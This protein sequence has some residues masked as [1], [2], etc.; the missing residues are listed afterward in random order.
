MPLF[1]RYYYTY[2][3]VSVINIAVPVAARTTFTRF[4]M[5]QF[6]VFRAGEA[7]WAIDDLLIGGYDRV[8]GSQLLESFDPIDES[9][10]VF[11]PGGQVVTGNC[12]AVSPVLYFDGTGGGQQYATTKIFTVTIRPVI[13]VN[14]S[15]D[16]SL[17]SG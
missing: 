9:N 15:F 2:R 17:P 1:V 10:W 8:N 7:A 3:S 13:A 12:S 6:G 4:R 16:N 14:A 5:W 11:Y